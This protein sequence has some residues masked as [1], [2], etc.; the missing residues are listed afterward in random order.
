MYLENCCLDLPAVLRTADRNEVLDVKTL[1]SSDTIFLA[2][3]SALEQATVHTGLIV[4]I[5][6]W[7]LLEEFRELLEAHDLLPRLEGVLH[8]TVLTILASAV[9]QDLGQSGSAWKALQ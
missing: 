4:V 6:I 1:V 2:C 9:L 5:E 3:L 7:D 8:S